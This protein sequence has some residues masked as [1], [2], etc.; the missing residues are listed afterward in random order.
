MDTIQTILNAMLREAISPQTAAVAIAAI[1]LNIHFGFTGLLN[2]GQSGFMLL[3][4]YGFAISVGHGLPLVVGGPDRL[5]GG[6]R[7]RAG[8]RG[9]DPEAAR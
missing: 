6:A 9:T 4:A 5:R 7:L 1:G 2:I 8:A 3:G